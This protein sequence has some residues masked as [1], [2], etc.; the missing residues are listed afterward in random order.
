MSHHA[1]FCNRNVHTCTF[2]LQNSALW[3]IGL[4]H[5]GICEMCL[6]GLLSECSYRVK[7]HQNIWRLCTC[8][9]NYQCLIFTW[10]AEAWPH[11][12][13]RLVAP[14][15]AT[16]T[17]HVL[18][19]TDIKKSDL[20]QSRA[21]WK[22]CHTLINTKGNYYSCSIDCCDELTDDLLIIS[23]IKWNCVTKTWN[24]APTHEAT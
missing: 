14:A 7:S 23:K 19:V 24:N 21:Q 5:C 10:V 20:L 22:S 4:V 11:D 18:L 1:P 17:W 3:E 9:F 16:T 8:W 12:S 13:V 6:L 15:K 2:L